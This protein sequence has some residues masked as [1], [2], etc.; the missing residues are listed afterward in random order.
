MNN[1]INEYSITMEPM[2]EST[3]EYLVVINGVVVGRGTVEE[4]QALIDELAQD[5]VKL[6]LV[7]VIMNAQ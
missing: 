4:C 7:F 3:W 6:H 1:I 2:N 5:H